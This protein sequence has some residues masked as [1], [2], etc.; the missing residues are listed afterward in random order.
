MA[1]PERFAADEMLGRLARW[2]RLLGQD[3]R[4]R[5][6]VDDATLLRMCKSDPGRRLLTRDTLLMKR[7]PVARSEIPALL[8]R[9]VGLEDQLSEVLNW[10][11]A[12]P[13]APRCAVCN[14]DLEPRPKVE[15]ESRVPKYVFETQDSFERCSSCGRIYWQATHWERIRAMVS[16]V[17]GTGA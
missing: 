13:L 10:S 7:R 8:V 2:L 6:R 11:G 3:V 4:Y 5:S 12:T 9:G 17:A 15:L 16:R 14:G 1:V